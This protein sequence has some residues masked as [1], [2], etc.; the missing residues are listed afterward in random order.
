M[1]NFFKKKKLYKDKDGNYVSEEDILREEHLKELSELGYTIEFYPKSNAYYP[2]FGEKYLE[3]GYGGY[4]N[5]WNH[6]DTGSFMTKDEATE[7]IE[8]HYE[9]N[10]E[11]YSP[12]KPPS[13]PDDDE[14]S[15]IIKF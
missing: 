8:L 2:K 13:Q 6:K 12:D 11:K 7:L 9:F 1:L 15:E 5:E 10:K 3:R 4:V 14:E